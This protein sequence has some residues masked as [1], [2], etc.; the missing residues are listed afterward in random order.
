MSASIP[1]HRTEHAPGLLA[2]HRTFLVSMALVAV[3]LVGAAVGKGLLMAGGSSGPS[4][5][6]PFA[7]DTVVAAP[8][9]A[10]V[11]QDDRPF[12][13]AALRGRPVLAFFGYTH[14]PD[15]CPATVG[16]LNKVLEQTDQGPTILFISID[17]ERDTPAFLRDYLKYLPAGYIG[18]TGSATQVRTTADA[19][20]VR[21]AR[22]ETGS[23][24]GY[25]MAHTADVY[26]IDAQGML[27]AHY[28]FGTGAPAI[29]DDLARLAAEATS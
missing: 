3:A 14:C 26:L 10:L 19:W 12:D 16:V 11:D 29:V 1:V 8:A 27:R 25:A 17:P 20:G 13:L 21:Y 15:V 7:Y 24:D 2:G 6:S 23:A 5:P 28:P 18:L 22:V 9:L 4:G